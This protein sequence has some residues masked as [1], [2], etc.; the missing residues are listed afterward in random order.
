M[1]SELHCHTHRGSN[2]RFRDSTVKVS[3]AVQKA[4]ELGFRGLAITDHESLCAHVE[5]LNALL[6]LREKTP[7]LDFSLILGNE[8]YL[9]D[10]NDPQIL[11]HSAPS[12]SFHHFLLLAKDAVGHHQLRLLSSRAWER[13][14]SYKGVDRPNTYYTDLKEIVSQNP[15]HLVASTACLGG[16]L[17]KLVAAGDTQGVYRFCSWCRQ[18]FGADNFFVEIQCGT[19]PEQVDFNKRILRFCKHFGF[20]WIITNDVHYLTGD[21]RQLHENFLNAQRDSDREM[22]DFYESTYFKGETEMRARLSYL[23][24]QDVEKGFANTV[25]VTEMCKAAADY[26]LFRDTVVPQRELPRFS[27]KRSLPCD[28]VKHP[29]IRHF[30]NSPHAQDHWLMKQ[31]EDGLERTHTVVTDTELDRIDYELHQIWAIS[32]KK[33]QRVSSYYNL[34]QLIVEIMWADDQGASIVGPARGSVGGW[35]IAYLMDIT[36]LNPIKWGTVPWRHL[37]ESRPDWP[38]VDIDTCAARRPHIFKAVKDVFGWN[39]CLNIAT[40]KTES[41]KSAIQTAARGLGYD[42]DAAREITGLVPVARGK[43]WSIHDCLNGTEDNGFIPIRE[44]VSKINQFP[45]LLETALEIEGLVCGRSSHASGFFIFNSAY[46][47]YVPMMKAPN[48]LFL[49]QW[50]M[51]ECEQCGAL[52]VDFLTIEGADK[53]QQCLQYLLDD[54][55]IQWKASLKATYDAYLHPDMLDYDTA[56]MWQLAADGQIADLFQMMTDVGA[57][58]IKRIHPTT[59]KE[60]SLTNSVMRLMGNEDGTPLDRFMTFKNDLSL[61]YREMKEAGL[62]ED[63]V[64]VLE[65][66]LLSNYGCSIEQEDVMLLVMDSRISGFDMKQANSIRKAIA[67]KKRSL[68]DE[69]RALFYEKGAQLGT[70]RV[71]LDYIWRCMVTPQLGYSF[72][73]NHTLPYSAIALQEMNLFYHYPHIYWQCA[74]LTVNASADP[75][76]QSRDSTNYGKIARAIGNM[77]QQGVH[78]ALPDINTANYGFM[79]DR[80]NNQ[81]IFGL[82]GISGVG[83]ELAAAIVQNRSYSSFAD[84]IAKVEPSTK[85]VISLVKAGAFDSLYPSQNRAQIMGVLIELLAGRNAEIKSSLGLRNL[86]SIQELGIIPTQFDFACRLNAYRAYIR[87]PELAHKEGKT[88]SALLDPTAQLFF[89]SSLQSHLTE[90]RDY[91]YTDNG[92]VIYLAKFEK[93]YESIISPLREWLDAPSTLAL[94]NEAIRSSYISDIWA[95]ECTGTVSHWEMDSLSFYY[96]EHELA[97]I[98]NAAYGVQPFTSLP[99]EPI[100]VDTPTRKVKM[101]DGSTNEVTYNRYQLTRIAGTVLDKDKIRSTTTLLTTDG[102]VT[103]KFYDGAFVHYNKQVSNILPDGTKHVIEKPWFKRGNL[104]IVTGFRRGDTFFPR[105]YRDSI[106]QHTV[107][108]ITQVYA[109]GT[110]ALK[111]ERERA[112]DT[113]TN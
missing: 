69:N 51:S 79:P 106:Y 12:G 100:V 93:F 98:N 53:I 13:S 82:K 23:D 54:H 17:A 87:R 34:V 101:P 11:D 110:L 77:Q 8:I 104:L 81:I 60:L 85:Q 88:K 25:A 78:I 18:I 46:T 22:G 103:V 20:E 99:E 58:A 24:V 6:D 57:P 72:S 63:E 66:Y 84:L 9:V 94:Y 109:D 49:S 97:H 27:E 28:P 64:K 32:E 1:F 36:Q 47:D 42:I 37:H 50:D 3:S 14:Y 92:V 55:I 61:W 108:L 107:N 80:E 45:G 2:I 76:N 26:G 90:V 16:Q 73:R 70:R 29:D 74:V 10:G 15:G 19:T 95:K 96:G 86:K 102:V 113:N 4:C 89:E 75:E 21:K 62:T 43:A 35:Y 44:F 48:G 40:F 33:G 91:V 111:A 38:D 65:K 7:S 41:A 31:I 68:V 39:R 67:K 59:L 83:D 56:Q 52:K 5:A 105:T 112:E 30:Y 71:F